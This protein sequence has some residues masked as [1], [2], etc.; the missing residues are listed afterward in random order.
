MPHKIQK[1]K[2]SRTCAKTYADY[3]SFKSYI[4]KDFNNR[5]GYCDSHDKFFGGYK[6]FQIDHFKPHSIP[7]FT[8]LKHDYLNLVYSCQSCNRAKSNKWE[9]VNG[10]ID[11]CETTYDDVVFRND[12][13]KIEHNGTDQGDFIYTNLNLFLQRHEL[14]WSVEK[15]E[16]QREE[17]NRLLDENIF[18]DESH[19]VEL[20]K[21]FRSVQNEII[22]YTSSLYVEISH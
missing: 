19:E 2:P 12:N 14:L 5:C 9:S 15:L 8:S 17:I 10:F 13:G 6:N 18:N 21:E 22:K 3:K 4:V 16:E 7:A 1:L 11:P 20:L